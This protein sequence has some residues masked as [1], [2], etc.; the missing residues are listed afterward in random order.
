MN[1]L[2]GEHDNIEV[3]HRLTEVQNFPLRLFI[4]RQ[5]HSIETCMLQHSEVLA[6][7]TL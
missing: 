6:K 3:L 1:L 5:V 4:E 7:Q 2:L